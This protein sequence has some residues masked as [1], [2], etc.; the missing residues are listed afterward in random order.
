[1]AVIGGGICGNVRDTVPAV[2]TL[3]AIPETAWQE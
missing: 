3:P 1:M 2:L